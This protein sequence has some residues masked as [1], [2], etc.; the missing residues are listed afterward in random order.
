MGQA[1]E[2]DT[3]GD[4]PLVVVTAKQDAQGGWMSAQN[5]LAGLSTNTSHVILPNASHAMVT[6][7]R[8][9]ADRSSRAIAAVVDS[10]RTATPLDPKAV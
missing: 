10:V 1:K 9:T 7:D 2:L 5:D 4:R 6:E 3:L 8:A